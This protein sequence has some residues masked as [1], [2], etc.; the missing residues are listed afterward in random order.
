[1]K[2]TVDGKNNT[3]IENESMKTKLKWR[4]RGDGITQEA[5]CCTKSPLL[6]LGSISAPH[7]FSNTS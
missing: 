3:N 5:S 7:L 2:Q 6:V 1:M 4:K